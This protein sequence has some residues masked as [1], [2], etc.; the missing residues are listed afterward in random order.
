MIPIKRYAD[1][2]NDP[3][4]LR[5][6]YSYG[7]ED[8]VRTILE[9]VKKE[10]DKALYAYTRRFDRAELTALAVSPEEIDAAVRSIDPELIAVMEEA[11]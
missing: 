4:F 3:I 2:R 5:E 11:A 8:T 10:G 6:S 1:M 7:V 9:T